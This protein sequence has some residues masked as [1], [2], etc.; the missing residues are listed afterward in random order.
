MNT[1]RQDYC[2]LYWTSFTTTADAIDAPSF[3]HHQ[4]EAQPELANYPIFTTTAPLLLLSLLL[5]LLVLLP[6]NTAS[7]KGLT[8]VD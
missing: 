5:M 1:L 8:S 3:Q 7:Q 4:Q 2:L 6:S